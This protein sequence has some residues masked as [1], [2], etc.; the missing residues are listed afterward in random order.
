MKASTLSFPSVFEPSFGNTE[1]SANDLLN[2][3]KLRHNNQWYVVGELAKKDGINP[4]RI[5]NSAPDE[6]DYELLFKSAL[7]TLIDKVEQPITITLGLPFSTFNIYK[8]PLAKV[9]EK[10]FFSVEYSTD[11]FTLN[12]TA[13]RS[14]FEIGQFDIIPE[15]VG[16]VIGI[17]KIYATQQPKNFIVVS[18]GYGTAEGGMAT[19]DGLQQRTCFSTHGIRYVV[20]NLQR[21]LN[22]LHYLELKNEFQIND[23]LMKGVMIANRKKIELRDMRKE[24]LNQYYRQ[25]I[26]PSIKNHITDRDFERCES[27]YL[28]GGGV[29]YDDLK[30]AFYDE[31]KDF[32]KIEAVPDS[33]NVASLGYLNNSYSLSATHARGCV[34]LDL[35]NSS[36]IISYFGA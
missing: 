22:K 34:G 11:T 13:R 16:G 5:I 31:F 29:H 3:I 30:D 18:L 23:S 20:S 6:R 33:Q 27:I 9:L 26:S 8:Q 1:N 4:Q 24:I 21:E 28:I 19:E 36:T 35:G 32:M 7:L 14:N 2:G 25:V 12:G 15:L 10:K 17:K